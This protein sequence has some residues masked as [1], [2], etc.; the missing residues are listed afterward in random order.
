MLRFAQG[1]MRGDYNGHKVFLGLIHAMVQKVNH[2]K[3]GVGM[4]NFAYAPAWDEFVQIVSIHSPRAHKFLASHFQ[5][6]TMRS[7]W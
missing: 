7:F 5:A 4:Q 2:E 6:R 1:I 3:R